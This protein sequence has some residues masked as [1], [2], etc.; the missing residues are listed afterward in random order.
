[1]TKENLVRKIREQQSIARGL[2]VEIAIM[3]KIAGAKNTL[4]VENIDVFDKLDETYDY[5]S[6]F[7]AVKTLDDIT[8]YLADALNFYL[9]VFNNHTAKMLEVNENER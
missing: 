6:L 8:K 5:K 9:K 1:M 4:K 3:E 7:S 2:N